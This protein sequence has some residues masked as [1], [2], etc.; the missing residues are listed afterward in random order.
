VLA[1]LLGNGEIG[2]V[3]IKASSQLLGQQKTYL[4]DV[5]AEAGG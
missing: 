1:S 5:G 4:W 3:Y 2:V